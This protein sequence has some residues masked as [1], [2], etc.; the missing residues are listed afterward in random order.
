MIFF[1]ADPYAP[2]GDEARRW[3]EEE[4]SKQRYA[5]AKP[6]WFDYLAEDVADFTCSPPKPEARWAEQH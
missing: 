6:T 3:A 4:L 1:G 2:D 5:E